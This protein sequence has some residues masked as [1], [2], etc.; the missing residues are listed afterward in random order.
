[1]STYYAVLTATGEAKLA[2]A[3]ALGTKLQLSKMAVGDGNGALP[4]PV[5]TQ[6]ALVRETYRADLNTLSPDPMNANQIIAEMVIPET[7]GGYW[8]REMGIYDAAGDLFAVANCPESYKPQMAEG[9]GRTQVLRMVL[10]VSSTAAVQLKID[11]SV[12]L[13]TRAYVES[14]ITVHQTGA[15]PHKQYKLRGAFTYLNANTQIASSHEG[16]IILD[17]TAGARTLTLP[18]NDAELGVRDFLVRRAD[19]T[20][21]RAKVQASGQDKIKFHTHLN[22][23]G[24]PF[25]VLMGAGDWWHLRSDGEGGWWPI[26]RHDSTP[27]GR[28]LFDT[29]TAF[30]AGGYG[31]LSGPVLVRADWPWLWDHAQQSGM[32]TS[33]AARAGMEGGWTTGDGSTT[34]RAPDLRGEFIRVLDEGRGVN[35]GRVAGSWQA[36]EIQ[37]H[38]HTIFRGLA[39]ANT[40]T[41]SNG[42]DNMS[43]S[44]TSGETG[45]DETRPRSIALPAR[46][47][48]I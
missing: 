24:Y 20:G 14:L 10:I 37:R 35:A 36:G 9:S 23:A 40:S 2:N 21:N 33:E 6:T 19:N 12:V 4:N 48:F 39:Q 3:T 43:F 7:E 44:G 45:G 41:S 42:G 16:V 32:L 27:L 11:P 13:A 30:P 28:P 8:L 17:A 18:L 26:A 31:A 38:S 5:R 25:L 15:D 46:A 22:A 34:F 29:T 1:M 47:K